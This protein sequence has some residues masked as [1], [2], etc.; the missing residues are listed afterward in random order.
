MPGHVPFLFQKSFFGTFFKDPNVV[1]R[2]RIQGP[3]CSMYGIFTYIY[4][5]FKPNV[6]KYTIH[7]A[8]GGWRSSWVLDQHISADSFDFRGVCIETSEL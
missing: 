8:Y 3:I 1:G 4:H 7:R 6:G 5:K 2:L